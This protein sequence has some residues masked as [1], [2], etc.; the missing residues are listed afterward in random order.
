MTWAT[1]AGK[2][3]R[4]KGLK[5]IQT[6]RAIRQLM[7]ASGGVVSFG[8]PNSSPTDFWEHDPVFLKVTTKD[9]LIGIYMRDVEGLH[10]IVPLI[11]ASIERYSADERLKQES[12]VLLATT[13][14][15]RQG[16]YS[17]C[18][19]LGLG[20]ILPVNKYEKLLIHWE[21]DGPQDVQCIMYMLPGKDWVQYKR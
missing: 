5:I 21:G 6:N 16:F 18:P 19:E 13:P 8:S 3:G 2:E 17:L 7:A 10:T 9:G 11:F 15:G 20:E 4:E 12:K 1:S 14:D